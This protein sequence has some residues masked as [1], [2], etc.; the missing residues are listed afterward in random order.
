MNSIGN[1]TAVSEVSTLLVLRH[2]NNS[3]GIVQN[4]NEQGNLIEV[5][6]DGSGI[7]TMLSVDSSAV[8]FLDF[9]TDF[10]Y[11][12]KNPADYSF[13]KVKEY[14]ARETAIGLQKY[15]E[16][17]SDNEKSNLYDYA[18]SIERVEAIRNQTKAGRGSFKVD[19]NFYQKPSEISSFQY[20][21]QMEDVPWDRLSEISLDRDKLECLGV[22][23]CLLKGYKTHELIPLALKNGKSAVKADARLQLRLNN[24]GE[25]V[26]CIYRVQD[27]PNFDQ[28][29]F[30]HR[31]SQE[32]EINLLN[33]GNMGRVVELLNEATGELIPSLISMDRLTNELFF[34]RTDFVRIPVVVCGVQL[35]RAQQRILKEGK[36]LFVEGMISRKGKSFCATLQFNAEKQ[37]IE[38]LFENDLKSAN[39]GGVK[40]FEKVIPTSFRGKPLRKWQIEKLKKGECVYIDGLESRGGKRYQ[41]YIRLEKVSGLLEFSFKNSKKL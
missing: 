1:H 33:S 14:E 19:N 13:F 26:V 3:V 23:D 25:V 39:G 2:S 35:D 29:F 37:C 38:F 40:G 4:V 22:L 20:R 27:R 15:L 5:Q 7:D 18:V 9:Y 28:L 6:P 16:S 30:G 31:F 24:D 41:G 8:S 17:S 21:F 10:Y 34:L 32:D 36:P 12:L 11:Q